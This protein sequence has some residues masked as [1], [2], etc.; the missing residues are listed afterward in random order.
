MATNIN[1]GEPISVD[2]KA[3]VQFV[4]ITD[5]D[6]KF[7]T[8]CIICVTGSSMCGKTEFMIKLMKFRHQLFKDDFD[9]ILYCS[10]ENMYLRY[11]PVVER[12]KNVCP[13]V[14]FISGL[15]NIEKL[16]LNLDT[17]SKLIFLDDL[18]ESIVKSAEMITLAIAEKH[19]SRITLVASFQNFFVQSP[20]FG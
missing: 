4:N 3:S 8:P 15:P 7:Q 20:R 19:H 16:H 1:S 12:I 2:P 13:N 10:P 18:Q 11:D 9:E 5:N 6:L 17:R 14:R